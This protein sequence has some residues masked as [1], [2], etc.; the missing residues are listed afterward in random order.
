M[1]MDAR[2]YYCTLSLSMFS[3]DEDKRTWTIALKYPIDGSPNEGS[4]RDELRI[5]WEKHVTSRNC[6][7]SSKQTH[8]KKIEVA[9]SM[10]YMIHRLSKEQLNS[11]F[12]TKRMLN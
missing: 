12:Q 4:S 8:K 7:V 11:R 5:T 9:L 6:L 3:H 2:K 1:M 10:L